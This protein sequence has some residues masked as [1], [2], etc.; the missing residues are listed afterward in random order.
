[1]FRLFSAIVVFGLLAAAAQGY[2]VATEPNPLFVDVAREAGLNDTFICGRKDVKGHI[3][4]TLGTGVALVDYDNDDDLDAFFVN[5]STLE[6]FPEGEEPINRL[7]QNQ[8][9]GQFVDVTEEAG[10]VR[11]GWG[12]GVCAGDYDNDG[13][14]DLYVTYWGQNLLYQNQGDGTFKEVTDHAGLIDDRKRWGAGCAFVDYDLDGHL[15][16]FVANYVDFDLSSAPEPG[17]CRW[18]GVPVMCG[19]RGLKGETNQLFRN[20]GDGTFE[21]VSERSGVASISTRYSMSVTTLDIQPDGWPDLYV[22]VDSLPSILFVNNQDGTFTDIGLASG[23]ALSQDGR[24]QAGMGSTAGDYNGDGLL[25][26]AK[27]NFSHDTANLYRNDGDEVFTE[28]TLGAGLGVN[29][30]YL[31]WGVLFRD[32][33]NDSWP[34]LFMVNGHVYPEVN[35]HLPDT[36]YRQRRILYRNLGNGRFDDISE[37]AGRAVIEPHSGRG[38][39]AGDYDNDGDIDLFISN[40]DDRPSLLQNQASGQR[41][42]VSL[43][44]VGTRSN[45]SAIGARVKLHTGDRIQVQEVRSGSSFMCHSDLRLHFGLGSQEIAEKIE[46]EWPGGGKEVLESIAA[47]RFYTITEGEGITSTKLPVKSPTEAAE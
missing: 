24:E 20:R 25:D 1:M 18:M 17:S 14:I 33:D 4:E 6:G 29:T 19:P 28:V 27:T 5:G 2:L 43:R 40:I 21:D 16:L 26:L 30:R 32:F 8:G 9:R 35:E 36:T 38:L 37:R 42:F 3:I 13:N 31:G 23:T 47:G 11:S 7:Y 12:Q 22:A 45:R 41:Q 10:L 44:L 34:D 39:A 46:I 15:D